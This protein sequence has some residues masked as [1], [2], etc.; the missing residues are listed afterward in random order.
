[1]DALDP[2]LQRLLDKQEIYEL[3]CRYCRGL[4]RLDHALLRSVYHDDATDHRG[5]F[6]GDA[7]TFCKF[8]IDVLSPM[9]GT[10]H[11][12]GNVL[13]EF[14]EAGD[15]TVAFG[16]CYFTAWHR[17]D[18]DG[19]AKDF[20]VGGRYV[21]RYEKRDGVWKIAHRSE[22]NDW[23]Q[24]VPAADSWLRKTPEALRGAPAPDDLTYDRDTL[25][26]Q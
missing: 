22:L 2:R 26:V 9:G 6:T 14:D 7:D 16:E 24:T 18:E 25:R 19:L 8:A 1:M 10:T 5:F 21:D 23:T 11:T 15:G 4:D 12:L 17:T 20:I 3:V 13:I